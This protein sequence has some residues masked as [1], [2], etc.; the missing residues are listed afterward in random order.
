MNTQWGF[1]GGRHRLAK[2]YLDMA[3]SDV[4]QSARIVQTITIEQ[5]D[6]LA[7]LHPQN[8]G[9]M[10]GGVVIQSE[11]LARGEWLGCVNSWNTHA[12]SFTASSMP[13]SATL[14]R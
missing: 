6:L 11:R 2:L 5:P 13:A 12:Q 3:L 9:D 10:V 1:G 8:S 14:T 7:V 4:C